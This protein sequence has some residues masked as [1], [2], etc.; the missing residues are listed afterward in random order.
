MHSDKYIEKI[1]YELARMYAA[2]W[3]HSQQL[4]EASVSTLN[5]EEWARANKHMFVTEACGIFYFCV[6]AEVSDQISKS[7]LE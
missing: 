6:P 4:S 1:S 5:P 7:G 3:Y 2:G